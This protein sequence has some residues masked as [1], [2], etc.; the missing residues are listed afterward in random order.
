MFVYI[1]NFASVIRLTIMGT[2]LVLGTPDNCIWMGAELIACTVFS[3]AFYLFCAMI[4]CLASKN[5]ENMHKI[6]TWNQNMHK[7][8]VKRISTDDADN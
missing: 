4:C 6:L 1:S 2:F 7:I 3:G 8:V 5:D